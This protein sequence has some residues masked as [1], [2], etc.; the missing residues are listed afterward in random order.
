MGTIS[1]GNGSHSEGKGSRALREASHSEGRYTKVEG[2]C[3]HAEGE[4]CTVADGA[5]CGH[6][7]GLMCHANGKYTHAEGQESTANGNASHVEGYGNVTG[8]N[9]ACA[10]AEGD[11]NSA[12]GYA[13]H[14]EGKKNF[15]SGEYQHVQGKYNVEDTENKYAHI[16]GGGAEGAR[17]NIHTIDWSGNAWFAGNIYVGGAGQN[18]ADVRSIV[19]AADLKPILLDDQMATTYLTDFSYGDE[20]LDAILKGRQILITTPS[21]GGIYTKSFSPVYM[22]QLPNKENEFLY[23]FYLTDEKDSL[24]LS[25]LGLGV[26][27]LPK[28]AQLK[29][30]LSK[31]YNEC[32]LQ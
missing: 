1:S 9:A 25:A 15:A 21:L 2:D 19:T 14:V 11:E 24:D 29:M 17:K 18:D 26:I 31:Q 6:A 22:Y 28:Y 7:E 10:H 30:K 20:A 27:Y 23:L 5:R 16:V 12:T 13:S 3:G 8:Q 4:Q 32:P